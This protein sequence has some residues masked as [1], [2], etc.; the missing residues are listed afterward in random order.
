M[1][2]CYLVLFCFLNFSSY[3]LGLAQ[4]LQLEEN[5]DNSMMCSVQG[6]KSL[7]NAVEKLTQNQV[8]LLNKVEEVNSSEKKVEEPSI[9]TPKPEVN[10]KHSNDVAP[11]PPPLPNGILNDKPPITSESD[12]LPPEPKL[13]EA[14]LKVEIKTEVKETDDNKAASNNNNTDSVPLVTET[15]KQGKET[16]LVQFASQRRVMCASSPIV[17]SVSIKLG[18]MKSDKNPQSQIFTL[19][20]RMLDAA[21]TLFLLFICPISA[22]C[23]HFYSRF[24]FSFI[25]VRQLQKLWRCLALT[26]QLFLIVFVSPTILI[27]LC[28]HALQFSSTFHTFLY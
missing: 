25:L 17:S 28:I 13:E 19:S 27:V 14:N 16:L 12:N 26:P 9:T 21:K 6:E 4:L 8:K 3:I 5:M 24:R 1:T 23:L 10:G 11:P 20:G 15:N 22:K 7:Q 18:I 2:A